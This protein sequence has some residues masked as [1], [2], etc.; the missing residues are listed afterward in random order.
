ML[1]KVIC[2]RPARGT[3]ADSTD[4]IGRHVRSLLFFSLARLVCS[5]PWQLQRCPNI[6]FVLHPASGISRF[7]F[8]CRDSYLLSLVVVA[9]GLAHTTPFCRCPILWFN[10]ETQDLWG[11]VC[12][13][14]RR[15]LPTKGTWA[16]YAE[17]LAS[18]LIIWPFCWCI[19]KVAQDLPDSMYGILIGDMSCVCVC[20]KSLGSI[21]MKAGPVP[22]YIYINKRAK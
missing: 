14:Y 12:R 13:N 9:V 10:K 4:S 20:P 16:I 21:L 2:P 7:P 17:S 15:C 1:W 8:P 5:A 6:W 22:L 3:E 11:F 18:G 19:C